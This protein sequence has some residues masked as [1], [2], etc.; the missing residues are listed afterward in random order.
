VLLACFGAAALAACDG[1]LPG[2]P[3]ATS[4]LGGSS[5]LSVSNTGLVGSAVQQASSEAFVLLDGL[6]TQSTSSAPALGGGGGSGGGGGTGTIVKTIDWTMPCRQGGTRNVSGTVTIT[7]GNG[8]ASVSSDLLVSFADCDV[9]RVVL[10][11]N[12]GVSLVGQATFVD[13]QPA[14]HTLHKGG[15]VLF[16]VQQSGTQGSVAFDCTITRDHDSGVKSA[17]G[18]VSWEFPIGTPVDGPGCGGS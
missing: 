9:G 11:G 4:S 7:R 16:T 17:T 14:T 5:T 13:G 12:P 10:Q 6:V 8:S 2:S 1:A 18:T 3:S 15:G